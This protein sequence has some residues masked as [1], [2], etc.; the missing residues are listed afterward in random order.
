MAQRRVVNDEYEI[1]SADPAALN[2]AAAAALAAA[3][4]EPDPVAELTED[5]LVYELPDTEV[6]L[7]GGYVTDDFEVFHTV[8]VR[9]LTGADEEAL[10]KATTVGRM[11]Q[12]ILE[13]GTVKVGSLDANREVLDS[14]LMGDRDTI[15]LGIRRATYGNDITFN[16][17]CNSCNEAHNVLVDLTK[18]VKIRELADPSDRNFSVKL[19]KGNYAD[20]SLPNGKVHREVLSNTERPE[21]EMDTVLLA[22]CLEA[23]GGTPSRGEDTARKMGVMDRRTVLAEIAKRNPGPELMNVKK[24]CPNCNEE[25]NLALSLAALF[26][27]Q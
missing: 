16:V 4:V 8:E 10:A 25:M 11:L 17:T 9:E 19:R 7:P 12:V 6:R 14:M 21:A 22:G 1:T 15:L 3:E 13:R 26:R 20:V 24:N 18:D 5:E 23:I 27:F 2:A